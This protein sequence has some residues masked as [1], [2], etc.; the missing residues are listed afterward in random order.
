M[1]RTEGLYLWLFSM[2]LFVLLF[3]VW[4]CV[5]VEKMSYQIG[6][7]ERDTHYLENENRY[8]KVRLNKLTALKRIEKIAREELGLVSPSRDDVII[9]LE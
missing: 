5:Q 4:Q 2:S 6:H 7:I 3:Y 8:L 1:Y 9:V